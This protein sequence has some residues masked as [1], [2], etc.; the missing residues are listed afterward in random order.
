MNDSMKHRFGYSLLEVL[1]ALGLTVVV[2]S[3]IASSVRLYLVILTDQKIKIER[4]QIARSV[5]TMIATDIRAGIQYK[6]TDYSGLE[7]L[8]E[9]QAMMT[10]AALPSLDDID[11]ADITDQDSAGGA[12]GAGGGGASADAGDTAAGESFIIDEENVSFRP[13]LLGSTS[14]L[15]LDISRLPR[16]DQYN[17][18][19]ASAESMNQ[20][21]ADVKSVAYF[22]SDAAEVVDQKIEFSIGVVG[23]LY[24]REIDRAVA[25]F[26]ND[27]SL[28]ETPDEH[29]KLLASEIAQ[30]EFRYFDGK[31]WLADWDSGEAGGFPP[32]IEISIVIDPARSARN[33]TT[34]A[35]NGFDANSMEIYRQVVQ[36][37]VAEII[38]EDDDG[39]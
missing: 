14:V 36:I 29:T 5:L 2:V 19:V 10:S 34:Y 20:T 38:V 26:Q 16:L 6:A 28:V 32:A 7:S 4:K 1:L 31:D 8:I 15:M 22:F 21:P 39:Q 33:N 9:S 12:T 27:F 13:T 23:G 35:F 11:D 25:A 30:I 3:I 18:L 37:P 24:R 17:P